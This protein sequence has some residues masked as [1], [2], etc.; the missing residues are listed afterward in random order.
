MGSIRS[1]F[2]SARRVR[3]SNGI[4]Y[5]RQIREILRLRR[6]LGRLGPAEYYDYRLFLDALPY[7]V[8][9]Q[10]LGW[11]GEKQL[12]SLN[13]VPWH[14]LANDKLAFY[15][16]MQGLGI[17]IPRTVVVYHERHR[18]FGSVPCF[19][20]RRGLADFLRRNAHWPLFAKPVHAAYGKGTALISGY[21]PQDDALRFADDRTRPVDQYVG[22]LLDP[23]ELGHI[24]QEVLQPH[25]A[26]EAICGKRLSSVRVM[27]LYRATGAQIHRV[28]WK[29]P[30]GANITDNYHH[31]AAG[32]LIAAVDPTT[33]VA[34]PP[35]IGIGLDWRRVE[36]HPDT[37]V[38]LTGVL[39]PQW[40]AVKEVALNGTRALPGLKFQHW[41]IAFA[42]SGPTALEVNL[43]AGGGTD[44]SQVAGTNGLLDSELV[45]LMNESA[46]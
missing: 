2:H 46:R 38:R 17:P 34:S 10:F 8:K 40:E 11:R 35:V 4:G 44:I 22:D 3:E 13:E 12:E 26:M 28:I 33:G 16:A 20:D 9:R 7:A 45:G 37:G 5:V 18:Y 31:G 23:G 36:Q 32:N 27:T 41:D 29:I 39:L 6:E 42:L 19:C 30:V 43:Y 25:A 21:I 14:A 1:L 15:A 24:F